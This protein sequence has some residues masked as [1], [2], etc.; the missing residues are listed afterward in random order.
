MLTRGDTYLIF[1]CEALVGAVKEGTTC[2]QEVPLTNG[3]CINPVSKLA[4]NDGTP[5]ACSWFYPL[6]IRTLEAW[7]VLPHLC[8]HPAPPQGHHGI[9]YSAG[10][11]DFSPASIYSI[12]ELKEFRQ[13]LSYPTFQ[14]EGH[15]L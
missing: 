1:T 11:E 7:I 10:L 3:L 12:P 9:L 15:Y 4:V 6:I 14:Q 5:L 2:Y 13:L 8:S